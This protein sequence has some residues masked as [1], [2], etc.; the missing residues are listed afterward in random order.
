MARPKKDKI[1]LTCNNCNEGFKVLP[2]DSKRKFCS[3]PCAQQYKGKDKS[4]LE[5]RKET[6][7]KKYGTEIAFKSKQVQDKY[8][9]NLMEKYG[10]ENPF[11]V[12]K[13]K[14]KA[15]KTIQE[16]YGEDIASK[17]SKISKKISDKLK[18]RQLPRKNFINL[19]WEKLKNYEK[20]IGMVPLF[21]KEELEDK[22]VNWQFKNKFKFQCN[23]CD[24]T[25]EVSLANGYLP[26]CK[27]SEYKG[28]SL[29]E[30]EMLIYLMQYLDKDQIK[31]NR[32]DILSNRY[33]L[34]FYI[35][36]LN[37]A[38]EVNGIYWHSESLGK[39]K[40]Y[41]LNKTIECEQQGIKLLQILDYEWK[42]KKPIIQSI[43]N[44]NIGVNLNKIY[45]R[46]CQIKEIKDTSITREFLNN[47]HVQGYT[48]S[49]VNLGLYYENELVSLMTFGKN[50]F[51]K[52]S[53]EMEI[54][55]FCNKLNTSILGGGN[56]LFKYFL[57]NFNEEKLNIIS[58]ADRRFFDGGL[59][60]KLGFEFITN[61]NPS[62][63]YWK[64]DNIL[65][66]MSCQKH[67]LPKL[68]EEGFNVDLSEYQ[69]MLENGWRRVWDCGNS[70]WVFYTK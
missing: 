42:Y 18:G 67:K 19:K 45:G 57:N 65:H 49:K 69:N 48:H 54:V 59:Y 13:F 31:L 37:L 9:Q 38:I 5:K 68:L 50:R 64:N 11:L 16:R 52:D 47:N 46:K 22:K 30:D 14:D 41:H 43:L 66:R 58:F 39:Y 55:R 32:R 44:N 15:T 7:L 25:T 62:Y 1:T 17:N 63:F 53:N 70:K 40:D 4:W 35:P 28:Y 26:S 51:K 2:Y 23:K 56:K 36:H 10:F 8:K 24:E 27:C 29:I 34:D 6:C 61:T 20:E 12:K 21:S 60:N 3:Q 33:E